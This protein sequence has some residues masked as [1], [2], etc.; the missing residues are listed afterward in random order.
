MKSTPPH[1]CDFSRVISQSKLTRRRVKIKGELPE[2]DYQ[3]K[4]AQAQF[5]WHPALMDNGTF[6]AVE[7][8]CLRT[9]TLSSDYPAMREI[10]HQFGLAMAWMDGTSARKMAEALKWMEVH[11]ATKREQLPNMDV[12]REQSVRKLAGSYWREVREC[13]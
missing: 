11:A 10:D 3:R 2:L 13:L 4:L 12:L 6:S 9:P 5:L 1:L 8:A 7:A